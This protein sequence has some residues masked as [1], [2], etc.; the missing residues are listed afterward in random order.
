[1][2][3]PSLLPVA[4]LPSHLPPA[5]SCGDVLE[6]SEKVSAEFSSIK[7]REAG[8]VWSATVWPRWTLQPPDTIA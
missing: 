2:A 5:S 3:T 4:S 7:R 1:M 8:R 6:K